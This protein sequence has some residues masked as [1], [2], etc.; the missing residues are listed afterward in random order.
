MTTTDN[1]S[2]LVDVLGSLHTDTDMPVQDW[3]HRDGRLITDDEADRIRD[4]P[5]GDFNAAVGLIHAE[6]ELRLDQAKVQQRLVELMEPNV[7][8][9]PE[10]TISEILPLLPPADRAETEEILARFRPLEP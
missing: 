4:T 7:L 3:R 10:A 5:V 8:T 1:V 6:T 2:L 9:A